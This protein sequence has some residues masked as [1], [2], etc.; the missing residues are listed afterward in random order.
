MV[1][2]CASLTPPK[3]IE[4]F[5]G[6]ITSPEVW[7][8]RWSYWRRHLT[9]EASPRERRR[10]SSVKARCV[11]PWDWLLGWN[12]K[13]ACWEVSFSILDKYSIQQMKWYGDKGSPCRT[14]FLP[15]KNQ[16]R[17][18]FTTTEYETVETHCMRTETNRLGNPS[19]RRRFCRKTH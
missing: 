15:R 13:L 8:K 16:W 11:S 12:R 6:F 2:L 18:P 5:C 9:E 10:M 3:K 17:L 19:C 4:D 1:C 14:P 7:P